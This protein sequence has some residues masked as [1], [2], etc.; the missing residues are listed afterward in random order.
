MWTVV[1]SLSAD[2]SVSA[3]AISEK[4]PKRPEGAR[5]RA[6]H[7]YPTRRSPSSVLMLDTTFGRSVAPLLNSSRAR[8]AVSWLTVTF[9]DSLKQYHADGE[10]VGLERECV[11]VVPALRS[12]VRVETGVGFDVRDELCRKP[13]LLH[14]NRMNTALGRS[15]QCGLRACPEGGRRSCLLPRTPISCTAPKRWPA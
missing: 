14:F 3:F 1:R 12:C 11:W 2:T 9:K 8:L 4:R 7:K 13:T 5:E 15:P 10:N 6:I